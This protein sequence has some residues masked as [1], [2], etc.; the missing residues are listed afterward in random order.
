MRTY[1]LCVRERD[2]RNMD[3]TYFA[4]DSEIRKQYRRFNAGETQL[5]VQLLPHSD[6]DVNIASHFQERVM[7][8]LDYALRG[9]SDSDMVV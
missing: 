3:H 5:T 2:V 8:V 9:N 4:T 1:V 7:H 6:P